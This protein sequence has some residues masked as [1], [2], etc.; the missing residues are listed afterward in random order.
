MPDENLNT[1]P[2]FYV[3]SRA[4]IPSRVEMWKSLRD[5]RGVSIISTWIDEAEPGATAD[6]SELWMRI[7]EEI[8]NADRILFYVEPDDFPLKGAL[9]EA[10]IAIAL[11]KP[12]FLVSPNCNFAA[13]SYRPIGSWIKH[14]LVMLCDSIEDA[15]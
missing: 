15:L 13:P 5:T 10:G 4:S 2:K 9:I 7:A 14:P 1:Y 11:N 3:I 8:S 6:L 12:I